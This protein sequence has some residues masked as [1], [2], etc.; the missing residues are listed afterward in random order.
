MTLEPSDAERVREIRSAVASYSTAYEALECIQRASEEKE[1]K[2]ESL[3]PVG[4]QKTGVIGE[5]YAL[6]YAKGQYEEAK[7][8]ENSQPVWDI[9]ATS[10]GGGRVR[11]QVKTVSGF[12]TTR[13]I[14]PIHPGF[15]ELWV[16]SLDKRF[17]PAG[18]WRIGKSALP[19]EGAETLKGKKCP[20]LDEDGTGGRFHD[21][22]GSEFLRNADNMVEALTRCL[23][24]VTGEETP[25]G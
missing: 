3:L 11:I 25:L 18:F 14:S 17:E 1:E 19:G 7:L 22:T 20:K 8:A 10:Q 16:L 15:D 6:L 2:K 13:R 12:S 21:G 24:C 5:F 9:E 23:E 4:D